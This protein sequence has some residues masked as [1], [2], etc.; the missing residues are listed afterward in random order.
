LL[1]CSEEIVV[2][3]AVAE[4]NNDSNNFFAFIFRL[5]IE[6]SQSGGG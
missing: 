4:A 2:A 1:N 3:G 6:N 5:V